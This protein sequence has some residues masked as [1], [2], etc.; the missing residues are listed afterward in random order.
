MRRLAKLLCGGV[1]A[2]TSW[3]SA[4]AQQAAP[5]AG[6][7]F[8]IFRYA[9]SSSLAMYAGYHAGRVLFVTGLLHNPRSAYQEAMGGI[10]KPFTGRAGSLIVATAIAYT[11]TGWYAQGYLI[12][13]F[14]LGRLR[15]DATAEIAQPFSPRGTRGFF[16]SP[17][18][19]MIDVTPHLRFGAA[20]YDDIEAGSAAAHTAGPAVQVLVPSGSITLDVVK[21]LSHAADEVHL[22]LRSS[23]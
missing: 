6:P 10:G 14:T 3:S 13:S 20:Y 18:N 1:L 22:F 11:N 8:M 17:G 2:A 16:V 23:L 12:P 4:A 5:A 9:S 7:S 21:S 15:L 19:V